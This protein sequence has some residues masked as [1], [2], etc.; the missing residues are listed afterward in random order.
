MTAAY[1]ITLITD[2]GQPG[3]LLDDIA[4]VYEEV[5]AE[6]PYNEGPRDV[7]HFIDRYHHEQDIRGF[8]LAVAR[9]GQTLAGFAY[10]LPLSSSTAWWEGF[11]DTVLS[12]D[13]TREDGHR[14]F[15]IMELAV[16]IPYRRQ[17]LGRALHA[18]LVDRNPA[19]RITL[20]VRPEAIG[21]TRLYAALG[22]QVV[23]LT[24]PWEGAPTYQCMIRAVAIG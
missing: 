11:S 1:P 9:H 7:A 20:A 13:F 22:Y 10:G 8:R 15:V 4:P 2:S 19:E 21:A 3:K 12:E 23:G 24:C 16:R 6:P 17:G 14:T 18:S 5:Y